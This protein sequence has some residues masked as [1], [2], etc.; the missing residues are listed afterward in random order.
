VA[1]YRKLDVWKLGHALAIETHRAAQKLRGAQYVW[2]RS[3]IIRAA[4]SI[5]ANI[6]EGS[7]QSTRKEFVRF[8]RYSIGSASELSI[9]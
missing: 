2:L 7:E 4:L 9:I 3:Q 6:V 8:L 5:P 1:D